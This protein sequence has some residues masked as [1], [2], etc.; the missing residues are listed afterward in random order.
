MNKCERCGKEFDGCPHSEICPECK[1]ILDELEREK[2]F[3]EFLGNNRGYAL[4]RLN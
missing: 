1:L 3:Q 2:K 4:L